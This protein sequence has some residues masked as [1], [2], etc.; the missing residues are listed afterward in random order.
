M[1]VAFGGLP[2][3]SGDFGWTRW[4]ERNLTSVPDTDVA[5]TEPVCVEDLVSLVREQA[6][7]GKVLMLG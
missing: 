7:T 3:A 4:S 1:P 2:S 6:I 5:E